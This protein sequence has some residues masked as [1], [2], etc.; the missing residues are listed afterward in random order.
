MRHWLPGWEVLTGAFAT[1]SIHGVAYSFGITV[2]IG[3]MAGPVGDQQHWQRAFS[4]QKGKEFRGY[5]LGALIFAVVPITMSLLGFI[6]CGQ[7]CSRAGCLCG[8]RVCAAGG[9]GGHQDAVALMGIV[10]VHGD[11][12]CRFGIHRGLGSLCWRLPRHGRHLQEVSQS[13][14]FGCPVRS[15]SRGLQLSG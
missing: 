7:S 4:F 6:R 9:T 2:T 13:I 10:R 11:D 8:I 3:L 15:G 1:S 12:S 5:L 14:G